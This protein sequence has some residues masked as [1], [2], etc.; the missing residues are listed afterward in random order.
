MA[1]ELDATF[2]EVI[3]DLSVSITHTAELSSHRRRDQPDFQG[4]GARVSQQQQTMSKQKC[5]RWGDRLWL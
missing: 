3:T 5:Q 2:S 1:E 4:S